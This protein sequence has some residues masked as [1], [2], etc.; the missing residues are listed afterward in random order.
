MTLN[1]KLKN[2]IIESKK[3]KKLTNSYEEITKV[4]FLLYCFKCFFILGSLLIRSLGEILKIRE[5]NCVY[6]QVFA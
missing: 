3:P 2:C 6:F 4:V 1:E 5:L